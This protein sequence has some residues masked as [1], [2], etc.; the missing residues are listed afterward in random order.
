[1]TLLGT[2]IPEPLDYDFILPRSPPPGPLA[3]AVLLGNEL[4]TLLFRPLRQPRVC[5]PRRARPSLEFRRPDR[6][7][8]QELLVLA[9]PAVLR[10]PRGQAQVA[11]HQRQVEAVQQRAVVQQ[12]RPLALL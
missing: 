2:T 1:M 9:P 4:L 3:L 8:H 7:V 5:P 11:A 6:Q 10:L 12:V